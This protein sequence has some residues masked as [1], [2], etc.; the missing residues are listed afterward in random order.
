MKAID[1][2]GDWDLKRVAARQ[3]TVASL[4]DVVELIQRDGGDFLVGGGLETQLN[5]L[6][7][8][9]SHVGW[10]NS[11]L[12]SIQRARDPFSWTGFL[13]S[14]DIPTAKVLK[15]IS[16][17][18]NLWLRK[19]IHSSGGLGVTWSSGSDPVAVTN[20][21]YFQ[22]FVPG[23]S[24]SSLHICNGSQASL[25]GVFLQLVGVPGSPSSSHS[26][27]E[28][29]T[30]SDFH[31]VP[32]FQFVGSIGP[33]NVELQKYHG[34]QQEQIATIGNAI[35]EFT[36]LRGVFGIDWVLDDRSRVIPVEINPR[37]TASGE[38][39]EKSTGISLVAAHLDAIQERCLPDIACSGLIGKA[40][41]FHE[42]EDVN[43]TEEFHEQLVLF[44]ND[45]WVADV[46]C[47][48][49]TLQDGRPVVT[50]FASQADL[51]A[52]YA[53]GQVR[54]RLMANLIR[55]RE[56]ID[57]AKKTGSRFASR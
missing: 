31:G 40:I 38:L 2:F 44:W 6:P 35:I 50:V 23:L 9:G 18:K 53:I 56:E 28:K 39:W 13:D 46:P 54:Q 30:A 55:V 20:I 26:M 27:V 21:D 47:P 3:I 51:P 48:G 41:A 29:T 11:P 14:A 12:T 33:L 34:I 42:G 32:P 49:M 5:D 1:L 57:R 24:L 4:R 43:V 37:P 16:D 15:H 19:K 36:Q 8:L 22:E 25:L 7:L 17:E 10:R 52:R 45:G